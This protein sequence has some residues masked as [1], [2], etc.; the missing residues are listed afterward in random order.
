[1]Q[2]GQIVA[3]FDRGATRRVSLPS[4]TSTTAETKTSRG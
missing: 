4:M 3:E 2:G 1:M